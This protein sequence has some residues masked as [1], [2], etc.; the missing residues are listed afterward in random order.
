MEDDGQD[1]V[2]YVIM[3]YNSDFIGDSDDDD[4]FND[5]DSNGTDNIA[6]EDTADYYTSK[7]NDLGA[8]V[9]SSAVVQQIQDPKELG[10]PV[11]EFKAL[12]YKD[13]CL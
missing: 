4:D 6:T 3:D 10:E 5:H 8:P 13:I 9:Q 7:V 11:W 1:I 2:N 12:Y